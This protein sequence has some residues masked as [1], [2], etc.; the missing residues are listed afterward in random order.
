MKKYTT[1]IET[2]KYNKQKNIALIGNSEGIQLALNLILEE[3]L[4]PSKKIKIFKMDTNNIETKEIDTLNENIDNILN[5]ELDLLIVVDLLQNTARSRYFSL[6]KVLE[7][8]IPIVFGFTRGLHF[9][10]LTYQNSGI[11]YSGVFKIISNYINSTKEKG[12]YAEFGVF[13]GHSFSIAYQGLKKV[14]VIDN[15]LAFD[16]FQ[17]IKNTNKDELQHFQD[18]DYFANVETFKL[19]MSIINMDLNRLKIIQ[20]DFKDTLNK[21]TKVDY[22][23]NK[24]AVANIDCD[25]YEPAKCALNFL[26]NTIIDGGIILFDDFDQMGANNNKG[27]RR[28]LKEW[29]EENKN[30]TVELYRTYAA[31][32]RAFIVHKS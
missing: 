21:Q 31:F 3:N 6:K 19:N 14:Q 25:V 23:I 4:L 16:T 17:G 20:G 7:K 22:K 11:S 12:D 2:V 15:F 24:I 32:G 5:V 26:T 29:L 10:N 30:I 9:N 1:F 13:D 18:G 28:A 8:G 27:E